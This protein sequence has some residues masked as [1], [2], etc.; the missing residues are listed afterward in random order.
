MCAIVHNR[1][2]IAVSK[3]ATLAVVALLSLSGCAL[4]R[5]PIAPLSSA[6]AAPELVGHWVTLPPASQPNFC[7][8]VSGEI[9]T[10]PLDA[11]DK[12]QIEVLA[13]LTAPGPPE[14][15]EWFV[16]DGYAT[17]LTNGTFL[18]LRPVAEGPEANISEA[19]RSDFAN[20][21]KEGDYIFVAY[22]L[23]KIGSIPRLTLSYV[24]LMNAGGSGRLA[25]EPKTHDFSTI[26]RVIADS[27]DHIA[28][29]IGTLTEADLFGSSCAFD[30]ID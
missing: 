29:Y 28:S 1:V 15:T 17:R 25:F 3:A 5:N 7:P 4:S 22:E 14:E 8:Y 13:V 9:R 6:I 12:R 23:Q 20:A 30:R 24:D 11:P 21:K 16:V 27:S 10:F 19:N 18:N 2:T 26:T